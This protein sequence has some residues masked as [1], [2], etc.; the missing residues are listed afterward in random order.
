MKNDTRNK[1]TKI[2]VRLDRK[3]LYFDNL[4]FLLPIMEQQSTKDEDTCSVSFC[5]TDVNID[6]L[7]MEGTE[8]VLRI[9]RGKN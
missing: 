2:Q 9:E 1:D 6:S 4:L 5:K 8:D 3:Y 7:N